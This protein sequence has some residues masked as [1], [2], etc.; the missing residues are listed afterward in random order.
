MLLWMSDAT[1]AD[2]ST[3]VGHTTEGAMANVDEATRFANTA[4]TADDPINGTDPDPANPDAANPDAADPDATDPD[5]ADATDADIQEY[6]TSSST[7]PEQG[8]PTVVQS[9]SPSPHGQGRSPAATPPVLPTVQVVSDTLARSQ[10]VV[11]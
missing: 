4:D 3:D 2:E 7:N 11:V 6:L 5:A 8:R 10:L 9:R 1:F